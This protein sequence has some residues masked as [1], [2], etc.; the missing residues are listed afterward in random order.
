MSDDANP[1]E[2]QG[3]AIETKD[4]DSQ[5]ALVV[6]LID[7]LSLDKDEAPAKIVGSGQYR[8]HHYPGDIDMTEPLVVCCGKKDSAAKIVKM[9]KTLAENIADAPAVYLGDFKFG[10]DDE[11]E[12]YRW[13]MDEMLS[14]KKRLPGGKTVTL[15]DIL[16]QGEPGVVKIDV[17]APTAGD[18]Y[19]EVTNWFVLKYKPDKSN[20]TVDLS[21]ASVDPKLS[22]KESLASE[23]DA[24]AGAENKKLKQVKRA[25]ALALAENDLDFVNR[26]AP[27]FQSSASL[28]NQ[29][30]DEMITMMEMWDKYGPRLSEFTMEL[31]CVQIDE[32]KNRLSVVESEDL[33]R[34]D[35]DRVFHAIDKALESCPRRIDVKQLDVASHILKDAIE[36]VTKRYLNDQ[37]GL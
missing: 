21:W 25:W 9:I 13:E 14:G 37:F 33:S 16:V 12:P 22:Y 1:V 10:V 31:V 6:S 8:L 28:M 34:V 3:T 2:Y 27:L 15:Q 17:W 19:R 5:S 36:K 18:R 11:G 20:K 32:F 26:M 35:A 23:V 24:L 7:L 30:V 4:L 29:V